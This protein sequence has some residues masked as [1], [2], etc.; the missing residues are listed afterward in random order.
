MLTAF[1]IES[2]QT[3]S[4]NS[5]D[6]LL[7]QLLVQGVSYRISDSYM[8]STAPNPLPPSFE[9]SS[10]DLQ[11][12]FL[13]FLSLTLTLTTASLGL[14]V[15]QW[16]R[17]YRIVDPQHANLRARLRIRQFRYPGL[18]EWKVFE[19][20][21]F[22]P[23]LI[24]IALG[25]FLG[26]LCTFTSSIQSHIG[27][28]NLALVFAWVAFFIL[29]TFA[30]SISSNCPYKIPFI[31]PLAGAIRRSLFRLPILHWLYIGPLKGTQ[32]RRARKWALGWLRLFLVT[33][34]RI[35]RALGTSWCSNVLRSLVTLWCL[36]CLPLGRVWSQQVG[37]VYG[38]FFRYV[39]LRLS[40]ASLQAKFLARYVW[41]CT[42]VFW[43]RLCLRRQTGRLDCTGRRREWL[44]QRRSIDWRAPRAAYRFHV[45]VATRI[46][47]RL[48]AFIDA[49][50][51]MPSKEACP[52][53]EPAVAT[54]ESRDV[55]MLVAVDDILLDDDLLRTTMRSVLGCGEH[56]PATA[57]NFVIQILSHRLPH[58]PPSIDTFD[59]PDL[60][61]LSLRAWRAVVEILGDALRAYSTARIDWPTSET[62]LSAVCG[63]ISIL[64]S[65][66]RALGDSTVSLQIRMDI[67]RLAGQ[68]DVRA[69]LLDSHVSRIGSLEE[70]WRFFGTVEGTRA[71]RDSLAPSLIHGRACRYA[72]SDPRMHS[73]AKH[74]S[75]RDELLAISPSVDDQVQFCE[76]VHGLMP[77]VAYFDTP[78][79]HVLGAPHNHILW[80]FEALLEW[81]LQGGATSDA[82]VEHYAILLRCFKW[83]PQ[84]A[85]KTFKHP[86]T[87][88]D[89]VSRILAMPRLARVRLL[90]AATD[91]LIVHVRGTPGMHVEYK[92]SS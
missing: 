16:L 75:S 44:G 87:V 82:L 73:C 2:Y 40:H 42:T 26:G 66:R 62:D 28:A 83:V 47:N 55:E 22:L 18:I 25:L 12:N 24:Q 74:V 52:L 5:T 90:E 8:N 77:F 57:V 88:Q 69:R 15:K 11:I 6:Q 89:F 20:A 35:P 59:P 41:G 72:L 64:Q 65:G 61:R 86:H 78:V 85:I 36:W 7:S 29:A 49:L 60:R 9:Y 71:K 63:A 27:R 37:S 54:D 67:S 79:P 14:L 33:C 1:L 51:L 81:A 45:L 4:P 32:H 68:R 84:A 19:I 10:S 23:L 46:P 48:R 3:L 70:A 91:S 30:P 58:G 92:V 76:L 34:K 53:E 31:L 80:C 38:Q 56:S 39:V 17:E 21:G 50:Q 13:W 43:T